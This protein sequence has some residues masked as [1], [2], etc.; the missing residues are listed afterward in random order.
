ML[1]RFATH[2]F[3]TNLQTCYTFESLSKTCNGVLT[4]TI[5]RATSHHCKLA[6]QVDQCN[7]TLL[8]NR[9]NGPERPLCQS[10]RR[11]LWSGPECPIRRTL[12]GLLSLHRHCRETLGIWQVSHGINMQALIF[13]IVVD[14]ILLARKKNSSAFEMRLPSMSISLYQW[15]NYIFRKKYYSSVI[16]LSCD[17]QIWVHGIVVDGIGDVAEQYVE[18]ANLRKGSKKEKLWGVY[19]SP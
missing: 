9:C 17:T 2:V 11:T 4:R 7:P 18:A 10:V 14:T 15:K 16:A 19:W 12:C 3:R 5:F 1:R 8:M 6:L 13:G